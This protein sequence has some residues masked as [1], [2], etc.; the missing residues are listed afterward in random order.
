MR[1]ALMIGIIVGLFAI[2]G[3]I[4]YDG[5]SCRVFAGQPTE[6]PVDQS[7]IVNKDG[8]TVVPETVVTA[9]LVADGA[10]CVRCKAIRCKSVRRCAGVCRCQKVVVE[11]QVIERPARHPLFACFAERLCSKKRVWSCSPCIPCAPVMEAP[12]MEVPVMEA[13]VTAAPVVE[14]VPDCGC[15]AVVKDGCR[16]RGRCRCQQDVKVNVRVRIR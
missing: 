13:P 4:C 9:Q 5:I 10:C 8:I 2:I 6:A 16:C 3:T 15:K 14:A 12:V 7:V 11:R 1:Y